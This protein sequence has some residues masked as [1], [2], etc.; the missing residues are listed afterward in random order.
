MKIIRNSVQPNYGNPEHDLVYVQKGFYKVSEAENLS[1]IQ[2]LTRLFPHNAKTILDAGCGIGLYHKIW[3]DAGYLVTGTDI[4]ETFLAEAKKRNPLA[5]YLQSNSADIKLSETFDVVTLIDPARKDG[6]VI[7]NLA[8]CAKRGALVFIE[9]RNPN[10]PRSIEFDRQFKTWR[11]GE[12]KYILSRREYNYAKQEM[13][14]EEITIDTKTDT[15]SI[16]D[17]SGHR[18][19]ALQCLTES[20]AA[21]GFTNI[22]FFDRS[23]AEPM[24][25]TNDAIY[26]IWVCGERV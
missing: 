18:L 23:T 10:H 7:R 17:M 20:M 8:K 12:N 5:N 16:L 2:N 14:W 25:L 19:A 26:K 11:C 13:E 22:R 21:A 15:L 9:A 3:T 24:E 1:N 4:S 6:L